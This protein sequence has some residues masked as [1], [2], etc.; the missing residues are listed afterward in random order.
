M[1]HINEDTAV[2]AWVSALDHEQRLDKKIIFS[3]RGIHIQLVNTHYWQSYFMHIDVKKLS[4]FITF[5]NILMKA[6]QF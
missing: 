4:I 6:K 1:W 5:M 2:G 3:L